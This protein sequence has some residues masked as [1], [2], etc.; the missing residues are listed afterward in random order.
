MTDIPR[1]RRLI[2]DAMYTMVQ[3]LKQLR[4]AESLM[5][6]PSPIRRAMRSSQPMTPAL[7]VTIRKHAKL[8]PDASYKEIAEV[9]NVDAG[10]VSE[11]V[12]GLR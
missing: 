7:A 5:T 2:A 10:R 3:V 6:R 11:A 12:R 9:Y 8:H 4:E 1:A